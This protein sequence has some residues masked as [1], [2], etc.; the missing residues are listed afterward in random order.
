MWATDN[1]IKFNDKNLRF[2]F[3]SRKRNDNREINIYWNYK[4]LNQ[5]EEMKYVGIYFDF[6][7]NFNAHIDHTV[8][9]SITL[10]NMLSRTA[11]AQWGLGHKVIVPIVTYGAP[12]WV[13]AIR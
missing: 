3:I 8:A 10:V 1:K 6:K 13:E 7:F 5:T 2:F 11:K 12:I 4:R 9:K